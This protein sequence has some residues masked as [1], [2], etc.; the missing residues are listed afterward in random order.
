M[1]V[2]D[3]WM[4]SICNYVYEPDKGDPDGGIAPGTPFEQIPDTWVC[5]ICG[6][7]KD[8]FVKV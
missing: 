4:C 1:A 6:A 2:K 7:G 5:P 8:A 3:T